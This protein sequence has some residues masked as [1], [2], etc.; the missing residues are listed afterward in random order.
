VLYITKTDI[1]INQRPAPIVLFNEISDI[2]AN[3]ETIHFKLDVKVNLS[4]HCLKLSKLKSMM[5][6]TIIYFT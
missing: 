5:L 1:N 2:F 3:N 6:F 4:C